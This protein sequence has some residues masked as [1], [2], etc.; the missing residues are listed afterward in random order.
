MVDQVAEITAQHDSPLSAPNAQQHRDHISAEG[1][2]KV[3]IRPLSVLKPHHYRKACSPLD[4]IGGSVLDWCL[5]YRY[6][7]SMSQS[8]GIIMHS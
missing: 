5:P 2:E 6:A 4:G 1:T 7:G 8:L 3:T